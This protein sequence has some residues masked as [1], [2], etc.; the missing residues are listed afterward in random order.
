VDT[1]EENSE[2]QQD[3]TPE[4]VM[5]ITEDNSNIRSGPA[6]KYDVLAVA[7]KGETFIATGNQETAKNGNIWYEIYLDESQEELGWACETIIQNQEQ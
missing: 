1:Q 4:L 5:V 2:S 7:D 3:E 6:K